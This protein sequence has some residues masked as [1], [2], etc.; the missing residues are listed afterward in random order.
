MKNTA[1][2]MTLFLTSI[3]TVFVTG[4]SPETGT[5]DSMALNPAVTITYH[6]AFQGETPSGELNLVVDMTIKNDGYE[7][8]ETSPSDF[9]V[10]VAGYSY[11]PSSSEL[12]V[13]R[14]PDGGKV[15]G[16]VTF[17]VPPHAATSRVGYRLNYTVESPYNVEWV[18]AEVAAVD[19]EA[20]PSKPAVNIA[21]STDFIWVSPPGVG[22][23]KVE[24]PG[25]MYLMVEMFIGNRGYESFRTTPDFFSVN[26]SSTA[27]SFTSSTEGLLIDWR[28]INLQNS[29]DFIGT[30]A[31]P[32]PREVAQS[33][34]QWD[35]KLNYTG[36][37]NYNIEWSRLNVSKY[38][39]NPDE[40]EL[41][42]V[43]L[44]DGETL[45]GKIAYAVAPELAGSHARYEMLYDEDTDHNVQWVDQ[46]DLEVDV[47]RDAIKYPAIKVTYSTSLVPKE[48]P[49][50]LYLVVE[51]KIENRGYESFD[52]SPGNFY[53]EVSY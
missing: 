36:T 4:C 13:V 1:V 28:D 40:T 10:E 33:F 11:K 19:A 9:F 2:V 23:L 37:R 25:A 20:T 22:Y 51:V 30:L 27:G 18:K 15:N 41:K 52:T 3:S 26:V 53:L 49:G 48:A 47:N 17:H 46:P 38:L 5:P 16:M 50:R 43:N 39:C 7:S 29:A 31:F 8:F 21:Y 44:K 34:Y 24:P 45:T 42:A 35:Y 14:L 12:P 32:V 6:A